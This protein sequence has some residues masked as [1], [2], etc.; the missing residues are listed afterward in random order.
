MSAYRIPIETKEQ[1]LT[2]VKEGIPVSQ[3]SKEHGVSSKTIYGWLSKG[4]LSQP[5]A[6]AL[7]RLRREKDDLLKLVGKLTLELSKEKRGK[8]GR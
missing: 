3:L 4:L 1:I 2:R 8:R 5:S 7:G 6:L